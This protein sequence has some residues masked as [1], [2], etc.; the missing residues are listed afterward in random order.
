VKATDAEEA[1][2]NGDKIGNGFYY[3]VLIAMNEAKV[4]FM[5]GG[6][7]ALHRYTGIYRDTKDLDLFVH[8]DDCER[9]LRALAAAG[10]HT[11]LTFPHWLGKAYCGE[12]FADLIFS[13]GNG[14]ARV[15]DLWFRHAAD[16]ELLGLPVKLC[17]VEETIWS[18]SFVMERERYDGADVA[19]LL[20]A[21]GEK[22]DWRRLLWRFGRHWRV[23]YSYIV[24]FGF[25]YPSH[26]ASIPAWV[27][28]DLSRKTEAEAE[29]DAAEAVCQGTLL[30]REQF[31]IDIQQWG[32]HDSRLV[33]E[34][35]M[36]A[37]QTRHWTRAI[38]GDKK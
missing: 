13:S 20:R 30:S 9:A 27:V 16:A 18:K 5:I 21:Y 29:T 31:L 1:G 35:N 22:L 23:L 25:I 10:C 12:Y 7:F 11:E 4:P 37:A 15:D 14:T 26:R 32:Y 33:P 36:T 8:P 3:R 38:N 24:L 17:P 19:H 34:G 6:A 2:E 28:R